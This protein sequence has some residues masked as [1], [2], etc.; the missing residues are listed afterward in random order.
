M[1][2]RILKMQLVLVLSAIPF[3]PCEHQLKTDIE[4]SDNFEKEAMEGN[5]FAS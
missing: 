5:I 2:T 1:H 4:V 3:N